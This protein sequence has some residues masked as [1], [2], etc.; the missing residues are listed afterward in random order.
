MNIT[1]L[2]RHVMVEL[3]GRKII[4]N[5]PLLGCTGG[6]LWSD[7]FRP[8]P[9][10]LQGDHTAVS[11]RN[12]V[13]TPIIKSQSG[14]QAVLFEERF[15]GKLGE[16]W[17]WL[18]ENPSSWRVRDGALEIRVEPGV[19][20]TVKNALVRK[21]P[22]RSSGKFAIDVT[23]TN[24]TTPTQQYEQAGITWYNDGKPV[25]K[26]VKELVDG[27]LMIIP[28][29]KPMSSETVQLRLIVTADSFIAQFRPNAEGEFRT[30]ET[31][32]LPAQAN[33]QVSIQCYNG[34]ADVEHW[35][36]FDDF[37]ISRLPD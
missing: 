2:D 27:K 13:L 28:G 36:R 18:R 32:S 22:D 14:Q 31:G 25:F 8:G 11:Y 12:I 37:R 30:A 3:N 33:D 26:I 24:T 29:R 19:A 6:A 17:S 10:Y 15:D 1:L 9:I 5:E 34:P 16:G 20:N 7:E 35:I 21:A 23:V 4:D